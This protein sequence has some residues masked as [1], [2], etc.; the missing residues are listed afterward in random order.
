ML[1]NFNGKEVVA[2]PYNQPRAQLSWTVQRNVCKYLHHRTPGSN[3]TT[4]GCSYTTNSNENYAVAAGCNAN[5][6][7]A[8]QS[9]TYITGEVPDP[10]S[11]Y[12]CADRGCGKA[13]QVRG[14]GLQTIA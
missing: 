10:K 5:H 4:S 1:S 12:M 13:I 3:V 11:A 8:K 2:F 9:F 6:G 14:K 7:W